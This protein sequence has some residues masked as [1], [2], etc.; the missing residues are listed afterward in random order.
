M[1]EL[2]RG[3]L[4]MRGKPR[5]RAP[6][7]QAYSPG[8]GNASGRNPTRRT[9]AVPKPRLTEPP[10]SLGTENSTGNS[11]LAKSG[12]RRR[13]HPSRSVCHFGRVHQWNSL[14]R[15]PGTIGRRHEGGRQIRAVYRTALSDSIIG[16]C[17]HLLCLPQRGVSRPSQRPPP[18]SREPRLQI[19]RQRRREH[20]QT[21]NDRPRFGGSCGRTDF[22]STPRI[23]NQTVVDD[24]DRDRKAE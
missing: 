18:V 2:S 9:R 10:R 11:G 21:L 13:G 19:P 22:G 15:R 24:V 23:S 7:Y 8:T 17:R 5:K 16:W 3:L 20:L 1:A 4:Y 12:P 6:R 14:C